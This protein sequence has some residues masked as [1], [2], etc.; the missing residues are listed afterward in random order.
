MLVEYLRSG[1]RR[2]RGRLW[3]GSLG[4]E[5]ELAELLSNLSLACD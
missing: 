2:E 3:G 1:R 4:V 5:G